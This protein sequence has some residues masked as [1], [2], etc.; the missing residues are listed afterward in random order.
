MSDLDSTVCLLN[1]LTIVR[2]NLDVSTL[3]LWN[4]QVITQL[5]HLMVSK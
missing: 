1:I 3:C 2:D 5:A 4:F